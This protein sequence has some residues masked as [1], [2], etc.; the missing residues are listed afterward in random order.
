MF[1]FVPQFFHMFGDSVYPYH[2]FATRKNVGSCPLPGSWSTKSLIFYNI[3]LFIAVMRMAGCC[4]MRKNLMSA[5][6]ELLNWKTR[7]TASG[8]VKLPSSPMANM[9]RAKALWRW[10]L[11]FHPKQSS[12]EWTEKLPR[13]IRSSSA[14]KGRKKKP[15]Q[16]WLVSLF[17]PDL[18]LNSNGT[19]ETLKS[20]WVYIIRAISVLLM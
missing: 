16:R 2:D 20:M 11:P 7:T 6:S 18:L 9:S 12:L 4:Q 5:A 17:R 3:V 19:S 13:T 14:S 10:Q 8:S 1:N 15:K